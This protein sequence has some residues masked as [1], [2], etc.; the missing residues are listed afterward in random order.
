MEK[1]AI[2]DLTPREAIRQFIS[3]FEAI[4]TF[5][6][7]L[8]YTIVEKEDLIPKLETNAALQGHLI[9]ELDI[10]QVRQDSNRQRDLKK[11]HTNG[12]NIKALKSTQDQILKEVNK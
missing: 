7:T 3:R 8:G 2:E 10:D 4:E 11:I 1:I 6:E 5:L 12:K 9:G